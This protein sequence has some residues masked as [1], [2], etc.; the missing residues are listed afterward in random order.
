MN[1]LQKLAWFNLIVIAAT[2]IVTA[3]AITIEIRIR[4]Y[5]TTGL[6]VFVALLL[7]L[8]FKSYLFKKSPNKV[9]SDERDELIQKRAITVAYTVF[10]WVFLISSFSLFLI[11][12][13]KN[14]VP[15]I[16]LPLMVIAGALFI[17]AVCSISILVQYGWTGKGEKS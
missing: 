4:G 9:L 15:T 8:K 2:I 11:I 6:W 5:S 3:L 16:T 12:G 1:R 14:V 17:Q 10:W 13:P 7:P